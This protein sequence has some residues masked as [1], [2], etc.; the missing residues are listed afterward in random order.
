VF[1]LARFALQTAIK[2]L[3]RYETELKSVALLRLAVV[4]RL[5]GR[6]HDAL[7]LL[8]EAEPLLDGAGNWHQGRLHLECANTLKDLGGSESR[9]SYLER[10]LSHYD[11]ARSCFIALGNHRYTAIVENNQGHLLSTL[12]RFDEA[13]IHLDRAR[14]LFELLQDN[15]RRAQVDETLAQLYLGCGKYQLAER[16]VN[17]SVDTL[18][19]SGE[20]AFLAEALTTAVLFFADWASATKQNPVLNE[21][22]A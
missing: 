4:E 9:R 10:A 3:A 5:A 13:C 11:K 20:D 21:H 18:E 6:F 12:S 8:D 7:A 17:Q 1:D 15:V 2:N 19:V 22:I 14:E 16:S